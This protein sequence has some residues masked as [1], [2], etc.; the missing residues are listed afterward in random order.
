MQ[1]LEKRVIYRV[2]TPI[3]PDKVVKDLHVINDGMAPGTYSK[4]EL[5]DFINELDKYRVTVDSD[6]KYITELVR[7]VYG[8]RI[9]E[10]GE[11]TFLLS[12]FDAEIVYSMTD[13]VLALGV[14]E[15]HIPLRDYIEDYEDL[16]DQTML[17]FDE[18]T[19]LEHLVADVIH[20]DSFELSATSYEDE[21]YFDYTGIDYDELKALSAMKLIDKD[22]KIYANDCQE[23]LIPE[24][25]Q[26]SCV[27]TGDG[28]INYYTHIEEKRMG[29]KQLIG[30]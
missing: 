10:C 21:A 28:N 19:D 14:D 26:A 27:F 15:C 5:N 17:E 11:I 16:Q 22:I 1:Q 2:E 13:A 24:L 12:Q 18:Y 8:K 7:S 25:M 23:L 29:V 9:P 6:E 3:N 20:Y 4:T 30:G